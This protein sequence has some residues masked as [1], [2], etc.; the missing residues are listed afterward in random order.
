MKYEPTIAIPYKFT[1]HY[2]AISIGYTYTC[3]CMLYT[4]TCNLVYTCSTG[5]SIEYF[6]MESDPHQ[7]YIVVMC[8]MIQ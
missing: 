4:C 7:V 2:N 6:I 3:T 1:S 8:N 5:I